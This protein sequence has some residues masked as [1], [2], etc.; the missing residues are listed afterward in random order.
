MV[1]QNP[2]S[3]LACRRL[4]W[5]GLDA[6]LL[7]ENDGQNAPPAEKRVERL[8]RAPASPQRERWPGSDP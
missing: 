4:V 5:I 2:R 6:P 7:V 1:V 8:T 3:A